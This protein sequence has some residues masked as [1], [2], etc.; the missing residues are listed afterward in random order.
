MADFG[1]LLDEE[2]WDSSRD[3]TFDRPPP[4]EGKE[5]RTKFVM[6]KT[7]KDGYRPPEKYYSIAGLPRIGLDIESYDPKLLVKGPGERRRFDEKGGIVGIGIGP[8]DRLEYYPI[9]TDE[10]MHKPRLFNNVEQLLV[11][12]RKDALDFTGEIVGANLLYD[13]IWLMIEHDIIFPQAKLRDIQV[14]EPLIDENKFSYSLDN[15]ALQYTGA[16]KSTSKLEEIYGQGY[17]ENMHRVDPGYSADYCIDDIAKSMDVFEKQ[18]VEIERQELQKVFDL[19]CRV[20]PVLLEFRKNGVRI[21][22]GSV[23]EATVKIRKKQKEYQEQLNR[24]AGSTI[25]VWSSDTIAAAFDRESIPYPLTKTGKPSF[26]KDWLEAHTSPLAQQIVNIRRLDKISGTF[27]ESYLLE[28]AVGDHIYG[29]FHQL[30][31]DA[32]GTVSGRFS[33]SNPNLQNIPVRDPELGPIC[34]GAF[35]PEEGC[36]WGSA[37]WSQIEYRMFVHFAHKFYN[38][39]HGT[40]A[41]VDA[42]A[43]DKSTDFHEKAAEL[44]GLSRSAS[45][46]IN[47]GVVY[48]M[49]VPSMAGNLGVSLEQAKEILS[50]F[51]DNMPFGKKLLEDCSRMADQD[52]FIRTLTGRKRRFTMY[53]AQLRNTKTGETF[54]FYG[55]YDNYAEWY[56]DKVA[57]HGHLIISKRPQKAKLHSALNALLQGSAADLMKVAMLKMY[58]AGLFTVIIPHLTVHDELDVSV[59]DNK[60]GREAF[61]T[62]VDMMEQAGRLRVPI[63]ADAK[64]GANWS[65]CK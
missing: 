25:D 11:D 48:G 61:Q 36:V 4:R 51:H 26:R 41:A 50:K 33:S 16:G 44:T 1:N 6:S 22:K 58:E 35:I 3:P 65:E 29:Q 60:E 10:D 21:D 49:G 30:R 23:E 47:F 56:Q 53:E 24:D 40:Q 15:L 5:A 8:R 42:Y 59:P 28:D 13:L 38:G 64:L 31:G 39:D 2:L 20:T 18:E 63:F 46:S 19:E 45:K 27:L 55:P 7:V 34:R 54:E 37:D 12:L 43:L 52:G 57:A 32:N 62:L 14:A 9:R 17:I